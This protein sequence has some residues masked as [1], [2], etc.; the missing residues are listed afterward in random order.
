MSN[1][2]L[3]TRRFLTIS[4][5]KKLC[6]SPCSEVREDKVLQDGVWWVY[7]DE[8]I[9]F[10]HPFS[11]FLYKGAARRLVVREADSCQL[12]GSHGFKTHASVLSW[13][14]SQAG[15]L[16][17]LLLFICHLRDRKGM[18]AL[19]FLLIVRWSLVTNGGRMLGTEFSSSD[20]SWKN[21]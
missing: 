7:G 5:I 20:L 2:K 19:V 6:Y 4:N 18:G 21:F 9:G 11:W 3:E 10:G 14:P 12:F 16:P 1:V 15:T 17:H 13:S 8:Y